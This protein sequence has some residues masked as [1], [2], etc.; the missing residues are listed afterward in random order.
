MTTRAELYGTVKMLRGL[1]QDIRISKMTPDQVNDIR[2]ELK[3]TGS[4]RS[5]SFLREIDAVCDLAIK[6]LQPEASL[7]KVVRDMIRGNPIEYAIVDVSE[8]DVGLG[9]WLDRH[10]P[11][12]GNSQ[13]D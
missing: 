9:A 2:K 3:S 13:K 6:A 10:L 4:I 12:H 1:F 8:P 11:Q 7:L 5:D